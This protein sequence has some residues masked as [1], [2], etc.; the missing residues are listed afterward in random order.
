[1]SRDEKSAGKRKKAVRRG[2]PGR[3]FVREKECKSILFEGGSDY[4]LNAYVGCHHACVYCFARFMN[5][6]TGHRERWGTYVD[7]KLNAAEILARRIRRAERK[8][9]FVS[10]VT[11]GWQPL[12]RRYK[13]TRGCLKILVENGFPVFV[14]SKSALVARDFDILAGHDA[15]LGVTLTTPSERLRKKVE[16]FSSTIRA[17]LGALEKAKSRGL[18]TFAMLGPLLPFLSDTPEAIARLMEMLKEREVDFFHWD[19]L[20]ARPGVWS[21]YREFLRRE[22]PELVERTS[23]VLF[24]REARAAYAEELGRRVADAAESCGL[25][26]RLR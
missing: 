2:A 16:P 3:P 12:E 20:N 8:R 1:M 11:D 23:S 25:G 19:T 5:R 14:L 9:V 6:F 15:E 7:V 10:R 26:G 18:R 24:D 17:R 13:V 21:S 22:R 4:S